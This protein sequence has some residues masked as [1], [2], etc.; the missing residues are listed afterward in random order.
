MAVNLSEPAE[1]FD[2]PGASLGVAAAGIRYAD[3]DDVLI[4]QFVDSAISSAV[5]TQNVFCAAPVYVAKEHLQ[6]HSPKAL[7]INSGNAN[8]VTGEQGMQAAYES[9]EA[10]AQQLGI[11]AQE[12]LPFSTGVIGEQL[13]MQ[14][15]KEGIQKSFSSLGE[16][17][18]LSA[19]KAIMTT[20]T[21][22][23]AVSRKIVINGNEVA[24]TGIAKGSG[25]ICPN[26]ATM[27]AYVVTDA[28]VSQSVLDELTIK[29]A[30]ES[31]NAIS[32]DGDTSTNDAFVI[33]ATQL[34]SNPCIDSMDDAAEL[35]DALKEVSQLLAQSIVRDG[36]GATKFVEVNVH[37]GANQQACEAVA[38]SLAHSPLVKTALFASDPN[39]GRLLMAIG[40]A[41]TPEIEADKVSVSINGIAIVSLGQPDENYTEEKGQTEFNK[42]ELVLDVALGDSPHSKTVWT[43]DLSHEYVSI[44]ADYRS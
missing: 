25:M 19:A 44:N 22:P 18:W 12:V 29:I 28:C 24:I 2:V 20:D 4:I 1:L 7:L 38:Y 33:T 16:G 39:W 11:K 15:M 32:V 10:I 40:K 13:P 42:S 43:T 8:A 6:S 3:R 41:P 23:K 9:C 31:F 17:D 30:N 21:L 34:A 14:A 35:Y 36:E 27:L 37:G 5:F 26:M